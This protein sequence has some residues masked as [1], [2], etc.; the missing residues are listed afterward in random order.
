MTED[1]AYAVRALAALGLLLAAVR[2]LLRRE[3]T[4]PPR[5]PWRPKPT[6]QGRRDLA[7]L[8]AVSIS[9]AYSRDRV[10]ER[11]KVLAEDLATL[12]RGTEDA[13]RP[14]DP[15]LTDYL[16][17]DHVGFRG[18]SRSSSS[19]DPGFLRRTEAVLDHLERRRHDSKGDSP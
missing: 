7:R 4:R 12:D 3:R 16:A 6:G 13:S 9:S 2:A 10:Q 18:G 5:L 11:L 17:E 15:L 14:E 1:L 19:Q 8:L